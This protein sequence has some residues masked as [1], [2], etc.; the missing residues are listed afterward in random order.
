[1]SDIRTD[2][3]DAG[4][5]DALVSDTP[6]TDLFVSI[7]GISLDPAWIEFAKLLERQLAAANADADRYKYARDRLLQLM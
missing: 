7:K 3:S 1:M 2:A 6:R 4:T 5:K